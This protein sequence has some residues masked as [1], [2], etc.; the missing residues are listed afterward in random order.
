M[1]IFVPQTSMESKH[2]VVQSEHAA[3]LQWM[4]IALLVMDFAFLLRLLFSDSSTPPQLLAMAALLLGY[5]VFSLVCAQRVKHAPPSGSTLLLQLGVDS[6]HVQLMCAFNGT[7]G[8]AFAALALVFVVIG[9]MSLNRA[10]SIALAV[11]SAALYVLST[12]ALEALGSHAMS[13]MHTLQAGGEMRTHLW[14]M[15][16]T[17]SF[18]AALLTGACLT[19]RR[20]LVAREKVIAQLREKQMRDEHLLALGT[21]AVTLTHEL[22]SPLNSLTLLVG[23]LQP[24]VQNQSSDA[25]VQQMH[26]IIGHCNAQLRQS[27]NQ[28]MYGHPQ[29]RMSL[30]L[31]DYCQQLVRDWAVTRPTVDVQLGASVSASVD[32]V[33]LPMGLKPVLL[34]LLNNAADASQSAGVNQVVLAV[35]VNAATITFFISDF[36]A[37]IDN[38]ILGQ[39]GMPVSSNKKHGHGL[40]LAISHA[41]LE[42]WQGSLRLLPL[43]VGTQAV[44]SLPRQAP[45]QSAHD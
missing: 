26:S 45:E 14:G 30:R 43:A 17:F 40:G 12:A 32:E 20:T 21:Q 7:L 29:Q 22:A 8:Q 42:R 34:N 28:R 35:E 15:A 16:T 25:I 41:A 6:L 11:L 5:F 37:G 24:L 9:A 44:V 19:L 27:L 39:V 36:G 38:A 1:E 3:P 10:K 23:E 31:N 33:S 4:R 2:A 13:G 18:S